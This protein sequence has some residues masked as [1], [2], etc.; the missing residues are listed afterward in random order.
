MLCAYTPVSCRFQTLVQWH[1]IFVYCCILQVSDPGTV[2]CYFYIL[3]YL[4][5]SDSVTVVCYF[6]ILLYSS[7]FRPWYCVCYFDILLYLHVSD[8]VS[9]VCY[10]DI[11]FYPSDFRHLPSCTL[12]PHTAVSL[13]YQLLIP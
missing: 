10:F 12:L 1:V 11:L 4:Q 6:D 5:V 8:P 2:I 7:G 13:W 9:V 3:L